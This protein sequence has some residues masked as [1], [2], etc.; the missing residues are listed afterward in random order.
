[1][2]GLVQ[3]QMSFSFI[4]VFNTGS[5]QNL[6]PVNYLKKIKHLA[7]ID[8]QINQTQVAGGFSRKINLIQVKFAIL[9]TAT[10]RLDLSRGAT[11]HQDFVSK[12][13]LNYLQIFQ[14]QSFGNL[15]RKGNLGVIFI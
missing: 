15:L 5:F 2:F 6:I 13:V 11:T 9:E 3:F 12:T 14:L 10:D 4:L 8:I 1:M 7:R